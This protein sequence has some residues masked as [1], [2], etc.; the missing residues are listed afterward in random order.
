MK[1]T[2]IVLSVIAFILLLGVISLYRIEAGMSDFRPVRAYY[3]TFDVA[4]C[5]NLTITDT[6]V[7][8]VE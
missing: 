6:D 1:Y 4:E 2:E 5:E 7:S 8:G 3:Q